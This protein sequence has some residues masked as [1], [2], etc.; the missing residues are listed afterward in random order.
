M[1]LEWVYAIASVIVVSLVSFVGVVTL[2]VRLERLRKVLLCL[3]SFSAGALLGGAFLHL[4]P[5]AAEAGFG[6]EIS[7]YVLAG[8]LVSFSVEKLVCWR[9]CHVPTSEEH[10]HPF[11]YMNL[12]GD[13]VHNF[14]DGLIIGTSYLAGVPLGIAT[15][16]AVIFH[17]IPQEMGDFGVLIHGGFS[18]R[19]AMTMNFLSALTAVAGTV[20]ALVV[21][22]FV[23]G[24]TSFLLPFAAGGFI[25]IA[26]S[27]LIPELHKQP[28]TKKAFGQLL[29]ILLGLGV[30]YWLLMI[31]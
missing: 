23:E 20:V 5:E 1:L 15:T 21:G 7:I 11:A 12:F 25:Y 22:G 2:S 13:G 28:G 26:S 19:K 9:H 6:M 17:E 27:D 8:M 10:P 14:I 4:L 3:V 18:I 24:L 30:M 31:G 16:V 29:F